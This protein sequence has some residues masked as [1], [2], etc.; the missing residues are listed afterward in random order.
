MKFV[1]RFVPNDGSI[2][3]L[4]RIKSEKLA[5]KIVMRTNQNMKLEDQGIGDEKEGLKINPVTTQG[6]IHNM[7]SI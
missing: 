4:I 5:R 1:Y 7:F 6:K 2:E 3:N